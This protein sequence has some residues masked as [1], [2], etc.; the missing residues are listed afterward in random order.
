MRTRLWLRTR[1]AARDRGSALFRRFERGR[2]RKKHQVFAALPDPVLGVVAGLL[3]VL[4]LAVAFDVGGLSEGTAR[5]H[6]AKL[7]SGNGGYLKSTHEAR[8]AGWF[9]VVVGLFV[10]ALTVIL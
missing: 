8:R 10:V 7:E 2:M 6:R 1:L 3:I 4:G 5:R 9:L